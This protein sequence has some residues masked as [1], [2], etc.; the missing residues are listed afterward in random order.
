MQP[1]YSCKDFRKTEVMGLVPP[2]A[3]KCS[4]FFIFFFF[5]FLDFSY[6]VCL[7]SLCISPYIS[8]SQQGGTAPQGMFREQWGALKEIFLKAGW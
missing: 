3:K 7:T 8:V 4:F 5:F 6:F 2:T 1:G